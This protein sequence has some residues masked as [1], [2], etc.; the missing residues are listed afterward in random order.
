MGCTVKK[1]TVHKYCC[2]CKEI[3]IP[4]ATPL[5]GRCDECDN[6]CGRC[7]VREVHKLVVY[8]AIKETPVRTCTV[9]GW[10]CPH[11]GCEVNG[12]ATPAAAPAAPAPAPPELP[13]RLP[14]PPK[15]TDAAPVQPET[16][17]RGMPGF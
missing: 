10:T 2:N 15:T 6:C 5:C 14:P 3:C 11:C 9:V 4:G 7:L 17:S 8:P 16:A 13:T 1:E 12:N